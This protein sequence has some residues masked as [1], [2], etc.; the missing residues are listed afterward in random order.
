MGLTT[1]APEK[2]VD[3]LNEDL[4][5]RRKECLFFRHWD[6]VQTQVT[7]RFQ[8]NWAVG[9]GPQLWHTPFS[10]LPVSPEDQLAV[11]VPHDNL[12]SHVHKYFFVDGA[13][14]TSRLAQ[15]GASARAQRVRGRRRPSLKR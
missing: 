6:H 9:T 10:D 4:G 13:S 15:E 1:R 7:G 12:R 2:L 3:E 14:E 5:S 8:S 11:E